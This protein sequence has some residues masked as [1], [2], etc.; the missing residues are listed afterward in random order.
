M[1]FCL[2]IPETEV[3][4]IMYI[5]VFSCPSNHAGP[6]G[7]TDLIWRNSSTLSSPPTMVNPKPWS[8]LT[9]VVWILSPLSWLGS[10]VKNGAVNKIE[11]KIS[12]FLVKINM[13]SISKNIIS[14]NF[15]TIWQLIIKCVHNLCYFYR[16]PFVEAK[17]VPDD[18]SNIEIHC[19]KITMTSITKYV[20]SKTN[21]K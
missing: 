10:R 17:M 11:S 1:K 7:T 18:T 3:F 4:D 6:L 14:W 16:R 9:S 12:F 19:V 21:K 5:P 2:K 20:G 15:L 8:D 13:Y